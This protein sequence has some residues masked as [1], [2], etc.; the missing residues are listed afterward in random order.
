VNDMAFIL[1]EGSFD[2][3][4]NFI[5]ICLDLAGKYISFEIEVESSDAF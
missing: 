3:G 2:D 1:T 4:D 5:C